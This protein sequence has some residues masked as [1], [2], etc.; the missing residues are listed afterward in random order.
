MTRQFLVVSVL[1]GLVTPV[2]ADVPEATNVMVGPILGLRLGGPSGSRAILGIEGGAG[3][4]PERVNAGFTRR[5]DTS[6]LYVELSPWLYVG[7]SL[8]VG[9]DSDERVFPVLGLWEGLPI[10]YPDCGDK[11]WQPVVTISAGYRYTGVH[12]LYL[13]PKA[14]TIFD[15]GICIH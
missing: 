7:A 4:G 1:A 13:A 15:G 11:G 5:L 10:T 6:F 8:G 9:V 2:E 12:E 3:W 14:G